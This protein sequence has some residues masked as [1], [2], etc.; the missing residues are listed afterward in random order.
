[1]RF[2]P[3]KIYAVD[4]DYKMIKNA[5]K[6]LMNVASK[7]KNFKSMVEENDEVDNNG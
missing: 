1:M 3:K 4:I 6:T 2:F 7:D 5:K